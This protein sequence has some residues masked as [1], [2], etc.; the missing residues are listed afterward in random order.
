VRSSVILGAQLV[1]SAAIGYA[2]QK[3]FA[4]YYGASVEKSVLDIAL[5]VPTM[6]VYLSG[7]G[8]THA[9]ILSLFTRLR[10]GQ[11]T[12]LDTP[13]SS[14]LN[15]SLLLLGIFMA[16]AILLSAPFARWLAPGLS[17]DAR[18]AT[19]T[20][21]LYTAPLALCY[22]VSSYLA[23]AANAWRIPIG[24]ELLLVVSRTAV[25]G[26]LVIV[27]RPIP[28]GRVAL[29][30]VVVSVLGTVIQWLALS[31]ATGLKYRL[32]IDLRDR[33]VREAIGQFGGFALVA[34][35]AQL[36]AAYWRRV[37]TLAGPDTVALLGFAFSIV[38]PIG[39]ILGK[40]FAFQF[41]QALAARMS[42]DQSRDIHKAMMRLLIGALFVG[43]IVAAATIGYATPVVRTLFSGG[44]FGTSQITQTAA[45]LRIMLVGLPGAVILWVA[46]YP[47][48]VAS[49]HAAAIVY[50][51]GYIAQMILLRA[52]FSHFKATAVPLSYTLCL[53]IQALLATVLLYRKTSRQLMLARV[54][55]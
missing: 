27:G 28:L 39:S 26:L 24:Q 2:F 51:S 17:E 37:G 18:S 6:L 29:V 34:V 25:I 40:V 48:L 16:A 14:L 8:L 20:L 1:A 9:I 11:S 49:R 35:S 12:D 55:A 54:A 53:W 30:L 41:G 19:Q 45:Y 7:F 23:A 52:L 46:L 21:I 44:A 3:V 22:G 31:R 47:L 32:K 36:A 43:G 15:T 50:V 38:D 33:S 4:F 10:H 42:S 13:F 5:S